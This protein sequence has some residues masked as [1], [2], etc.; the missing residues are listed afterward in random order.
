MT[1]L[2]FGCGL[3]Y[4]LI[5]GTLGYW[6]SEISI[7]IGIIGMFS[8]LMLPYSL[9]I[10]WA[11][12][13]DSR[14]A[15]LTRRDLP[16]RIGWILI[17]QISLVLSLVGLLLSVG[18]EHVAVAAACC[19]I[20]A[21]AGATQDISVD[22][23]RIELERRHESPL[24]LS[25]YQIGYRLALVISD[26]IVFFLASKLGWQLAYAACLSLFGFSVAAAFMARADARCLESNQS[27]GENGDKQGFTGTYR[28][29]I[30]RIPLLSWAIIGTYRMPDVI[31]YPMISPLYHE[32]G[33]NRGLLGS[34]HIV[35]G[36]PASVLAIALAGGCIW[37]HGLARAMILGGLIQTTSIISLAAVGIGYANIAIVGLS[38]VL[39]NVATSFTGVA[40]VAYLSSFVNSRATASQYAF[41]TS[42]YSIFGKLLGG[43][44]GVAV[45][46]LRS[47][48]E[49]VHAYGSFFAICAGLSLLTCLMFLMFS[50]AEQTA[51]TGW[52]G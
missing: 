29:L 22:A 5:G 7:P 2:G 25:C 40:L 18:S 9:K 13:L 3:P 14:P 33:V 8:W 43:L 51:R 19:L 39:E 37:R 34:L 11:H 26:G 24:F 52:G 23:L 31:I 4:P 28:D 36:L 48:G 44:S 15:P 50:R 16:H 27:C 42:V 10:I 45:A 32:S 41:L 12:Y 49:G 46:T 38:I 17:S 6:L 21:I 20:A 47:S 35:L 30:R 1:G